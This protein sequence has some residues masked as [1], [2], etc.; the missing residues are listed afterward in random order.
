M[1]MV[2][3]Y[4]HVLL[5]IAACHVCQKLAAC[6]ENLDEDQFTEHVRLPY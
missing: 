1:M 5:F 2:P 3:A 4:G 6:F